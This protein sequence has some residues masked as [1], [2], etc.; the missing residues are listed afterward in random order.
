MPTFYPGIGQ[1]A[2][3]TPQFHHGMLLSLDVKI[4]SPIVFFGNANFSLVKPIKLASHS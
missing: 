1:Q 3:S 4:L 2:P